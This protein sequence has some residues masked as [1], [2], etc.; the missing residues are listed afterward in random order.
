MLKNV[1]NQVVLTTLLLLPFSIISQNLVIDYENPAFIEVCESGEFIVKLTAGM[2]PATNIQ[3]EVWLPD[4]ITYESGSINNATE[5]D[6]S[7]LNRPKF[8]VNNLS[9]FENTEFDISANLSCQIISDI[10]SGKLFANTISVNYNGISDRIITQPYTVETGL[11]VITDITPE[12]TSGKYGDVITRRITVRNTRLAKIRNIELT[13]LNRGGLSIFTNG[14]N[15]SFD[16]THYYATFDESHFR[17]IGNRDEFFDFNEELVIT[18][19]ITLDNCGKSL[20]QTNSY[21]TLNWGCNGDICQSTTRS[22]TINIEEYATIASFE[23][24]SDMV[25]PGDFCSGGIYTESLSATNTGDDVANNFKITVFENQNGRDTSSIVATSGGIPIP[26]TIDTILGVT[27]NCTPDLVPGFTLQFDEIRINQTIDLSWQ[28]TVCADACDQAFPPLSW[29]YSFDRVC[30][31]DSVQT[32]TVNLYQSELKRLLKDS[33]SYNIGQYIR[34]GSRHSLRY[35]LFSDI[36][37]DSTGTI[38]IVLN[39]PCGYS[40]SNPSFMLGGQTPSNTNINNT[41]LNTFVT[42]NF[43]LPFPSDHVFDDFFLDYTCVDSCIIDGE[44]K[45]RALVSTCSQF[46]LPCWFNDIRG[47][48]VEI[49]GTFP[50]GIIDTNQFKITTTY[51]SDTPDLNC[52]LTDCE[53][54]G[55]QFLCEDEININSHPFEAYIDFESDF[56]RK[57]LGLKDSDDNRIADD[58]SVAPIDE[59]RSDRFMPGDTSIT[60]MSGIIVNDLIPVESENVKFRVCFEGHLNDVFFSDGVPVR[61][62]PADLQPSDKALFR[63]KDGFKE[64]SAVLKIVDKDTGN[65]YECPMDRISKVEDKLYSISVVNTRP[66]IPFDDWRLLSF[67]YS[68]NL[69]SASTISGSTIPA[70]FALEEGDSVYFEAQ[71]RL[72]FN[73]DL[74]VL[75]MRHYSE[76][77]LYSNPDDV[78]ENFSCGRPR[79]NFQITGYQLRRN[80]GNFG[81][82]PCEEFEQPVGSNFNLSLGKPNFFPKE[83]RPLIQIPQWDL[84]LG[85]GYE[86]VQ[87]KVVN[88]GMNNFPAT[89]SN[90][91][92]NPNFQ[93][94]VY[95]FNILQYQNPLYDEGFYFNI[96]HKFKPL[97]IACS[98]EEGSELKLIGTYNYLHD[99]PEFPDSEMDTLG[100]TEGFKPLIANLDMIATNPNYVS[101]DNTA[102][103]DIKLENK[104]NNEGRN[105][106]MYLDSRSNRIFDFVVTNTNTGQTITPDNGIFQL[107][108]FNRNDINNYNI[109]SAINFCGADSLD[110]YFGWNCEPLQSFNAF[111]CNRDT[112]QLNVFAPLPELEMT[113]TSPLDSVELCDTIPY[114]T[115]EVFNADLGSAFDLNLK[116]LMPTGMTILSGSSQVSYTSAS[117]NFVSITDPQDLGNSNYS[118]TINDIIS[119]INNDGLPGVVNSPQNSFSI[120]FLG[121]A[122]CGLIAS[123]PAVANISAK[124]SCDEPTNT[125]SK[126][127]EEINI[128]GVVPD[129]ETSIT[130]DG[131]AIVSCGDELDLTIRVQAS[132][133]TVMGDSILLTLPPGINYVN[134]SYNNIENAVTTA[135]SILTRGDF[136]VLS[137]AMIEGL[138]NNSNIRFSFKT[139]GYG[140]AA[141]QDETIQVQTIQ[142]KEAFCKT[143]NDFCP[144]FV[145]SGIGFIRVEVEFAQWQFT[146]FT[147]SVGT[148]GID[149]VLNG[150]NNGSDTQNPLEVSFF[151][152]S[153]SNGFFSSGD[154]FIFDRTLMPNEIINGV[155]S[156]SGILG[157]DE[158]DICNVIAVIS[159][160]NNCTCFTEQIML[161]GQQVVEMDQ[162]TCSEEIIQVGVSAVSGA[163]YYWDTPINLSCS[164]CS[165]ADFNFLNT[166]N[167]VQ[168]FNYILTENLGGC[169]TLYL[170]SVDVFP[171]PQVITPDSEVCEGEP[172]TLTTTP[173]Q[174]VIWNGPGLNNSNVLNPVVSPSQT[175]TYIANIS[176]ANCSNIDSVTIE[177][178]P[179]PIANAGPDTSLCNFAGSFQ[180]EAFFDL[181]YTYFWEPNFLLNDFLIHN[182]TVT[183]NL[184]TE[185]V[186]IVTDNNTSCSATDTVF[187]D[188]GVTP[189]LSVSNDVTICGG[190]SVELLVNGADTYIWTTV[191]T[192]I[193]N[194][195]C[196]SIMVSPTQTTTYYVTGTTAGMCDA[197][198][199]IMVTIEGELQFT[200][201]FHEEC[202][203][204][205]VFIDD[206]K[207]TQDTIYR[208]TMQSTLFSCDSIVINRINFI[209]N[210]TELDTILCE[211]NMIDLFGDGNAFMPSE[212][213]TCKTITFN[214]CDSVICYN[215]SLLQGPNLVQTTFTFPLSNDSVRLVGLPPNFSYSWTPSTGLSCTD[216]QEPYALPDSSTVYTARVF[217]DE[218]CPTEARFEV[219]KCNIEKVTIPNIFSPNGDT[220]NEM[221]CPVN[222][223]SEEIISMK[224]FNRWGQKIYDKSGPDAK[225]DGKFKGEDQPVGVYV[226]IIELGCNGD[227]EEPIVGDVTLLR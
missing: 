114:H 157:I 158:T 59:V 113:I 171:L 208:D 134:G 51:I 53:E 197:Q 25:A 97:P 115:I 36:L 80:I 23:F 89:V 69:P 165:T 101:N 52:S 121:F 181:D 15:T 140:D 50:L 199:S 37:D 104:S 143:S 55:L 182:P 44:F 14:V 117:G 93:G 90:Q 92:I 227:N 4:G 204:D 60:R 201:I 88:M 33:V 76:T 221:F 192:L 103:W 176:N 83:V 139:T 29:I 24:T 161:S 223:G 72:I 96:F 183:A 125:L 172:I 177:I 195:S 202:E 13:D 3:V 31:V 184:S 214:D 148:S 43:D 225:W 118:W 119:A 79:N 150:T 146:N 190:E 10:N 122:N 144:V 210:R 85:F 128:K 120:R 63:S 156:I 109:S 169:P 49:D 155:F 27:V 124:N 174:S 26:F 75:N 123:A 67:T 9:S 46:F 70:G 153:D 218:G 200:N 138:P 35:D 180:L 42:L 98:F 18:E 209:P 71:H 100:S 107:G 152:D 196:Q 127:G 136:T 198:D 7:N 105:V 82:L 187:V 62:Y 215:V 40:W 145:Q 179:G 73:A 86:L 66:V 133:M 222:L 160:E 32:S 41:G 16:S 81:A 147:S 132:G 112:F 110:V 137:W 48:R 87:S 166:T 135:P 173:A 194:D 56:Y 45:G 106:W 22:A 205:T 65:E 17:N 77:V 129:Y 21:L 213:D 34:N 12:T 99:F 84:L 212:G 206:K 159:P 216:C 61:V 28:N 149:F 5:F 170:I 111:A 226:Y 141:C 68:L 163:N 2:E 74:R 162:T 189:E 224:I 47:S 58:G 211:G 11:L 57:N 94:G 193:C 217:N 78:E 151:L 64:L 185:F 131:A 164:D 54:F 142:S 219:N 154:V 207:F 39:L 19:Q 95:K 186:L 178:I 167:D 102:N 203:G 30:P 191:S 20:E 1:L 168:T 116:V 91:D 130:P 38:Q 6:I 188:F 108:T 126:P 175:A 220:R 8:T